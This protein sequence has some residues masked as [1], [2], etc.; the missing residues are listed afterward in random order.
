MR[1]E[2]CDDPQEWNKAVLALNG[3]LYHSWQWGQL[4]LSQG[5]TPWRVLAEEHGMPRAALQILERRLPLIPLSILYAPK[6]IAHRLTGLQHLAEL[7]GWLS[8]F[9]R[10]RHAIFLRIDPEILDT[11]ED[12]KGQ[13]KALGFRWLSEEQWSFWG[14]FPRAW[15]VT[16][17]SLP[18]DELL[19]RMRRSHRYL[20]GRAAKSGA[21]IAASTDVSDLR[22]LYGLIL[23]SADRQQFPVRSLDRF[24]RLGDLFLRDG[25]GVIWLARSDGRPVAGILCARFGESAYYL[26]GGFDSACRVNANEALHWKAIQWSKQMGCREYN[27]IGAGTRYPPQEGHRGYGTYSFK[28]G[29]G[30]VLRYYAGYFDLVGNRPAYSLFRY[31]EN[32]ALGKAYHFLAVLRPSLKRFR[33]I[34][35]TLAK[36]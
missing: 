21:S 23:K 33:E 30:S 31:L 27:L 12:A 10:K 8:G 6:G 19:R 32:K 16:D 35:P 25:Q 17:V 15:M 14:N 2:L 20:I 36:A 29:F 24:L 22:E 26:H 3:T 28:K 4:C 9:L 13:L 1:I 5:W 34:L 11:D 18:E 7:V